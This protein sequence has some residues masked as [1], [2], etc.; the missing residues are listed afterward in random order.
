MSNIQKGY[1]TRYMEL[2]KSSIISSITNDTRNDIYSN[3]M[4]SVG[5]RE[6][7]KAIAL[8]LLLCASAATAATALMPLALQSHRI[9]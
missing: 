4:H 2:R 6:S 3:H 1:H 5:L 8:A 9:D 7:L